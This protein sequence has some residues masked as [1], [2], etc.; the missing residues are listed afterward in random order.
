[1][2]ERD[3]LFFNRIEKVGSTSMSDL[4]FA[5]SKINYFTPHHNIRYDTKPMLHSFEEQYD[6]AEDLLSLP[7][8][9]S[10]VEHRNWLN[11]TD[12][13]LPRP[14]YMNL[15]RHPIQ[16]VISAYYY[17]RTPKVH[18]RYLIRS[19]QSS[20]QADKTLGMSFN[21]CFK[22]QIKPFCVFDS[23]IQ[24]NRDWRRFTL[25]FCGD[26]KICAYV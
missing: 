15:V 9:S 18:A 22:R 4:L 11:F 21:E 19:N 23:H 16:K 5:L 2:A 20:T 14:I 3:I 13:D 1:M 8:P 24:Y 6:F 26:Q 17:L 10:H 7:E 12:F 25:H